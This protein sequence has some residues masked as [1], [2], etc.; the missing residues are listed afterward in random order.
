MLL[1]A[2]R[3]AA[4]SALLSKL[5]KN[6]DFREQLLAFGRE[7]RLGAGTAPF[8]LEFLLQRLE[9]P[10]ASGALIVGACSR[11]CHD[12]ASEAL[13]WLNVAFLVLRGLQQTRSELATSLAPAVRTIKSM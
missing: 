13:S 10:A 6:P 3:N 11:Q 7:E 4:L 8:Q 1:T 5:A 12:A 9:L 2:E